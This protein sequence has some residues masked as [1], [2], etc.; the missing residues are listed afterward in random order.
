MKIEYLGVELDDLDGVVPVSP[1]QYTH[2]HQGEIQGKLDKG[3]V[4]LPNNRKLTIDFDERT[5]EKLRPFGAK[6]VMEFNN[7]PSL[8]GKKYKI[9]RRD[10]KRCRVHLVEE[11]K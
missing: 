6:E 11:S 2:V 8:V 10:W 7:F 1:E 3:F 5:M 9:M 4:F